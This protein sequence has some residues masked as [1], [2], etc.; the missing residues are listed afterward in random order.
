MLLSLS[1]SAMINDDLLISY[2]KENGIKYITQRAV[3][4]IEENYLNEEEI[5]EIGL[6]ID[7]GIKNIEI[8]LEMKL[9]T[10]HY[11]KNKIHYFISSKR[12][13]SHVYGGYNQ[14]TYNKPFILLSYAKEKKSP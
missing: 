13:P 2:L 11:Q 10:V 4:W 1:V 6:K 5:K 3:L 14:N 12:F 8:V 7:E 9:D